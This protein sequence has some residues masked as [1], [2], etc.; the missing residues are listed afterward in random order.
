MT[1]VGSA[2]AAALPAT[3]VAAIQQ[4]CWR[5][6]AWTT[7]AIFGW[8]L[9]LDQLLPP[10]IP[11]LASDGA[12]VVLARD[13]SPLRAFANRQGVW[14]YPVTRAQV[15][16]L[17]VA[18][19]LGYE[20][21][22]FR[23]HLGINPLAIARAGAQWM[24]H[25]KLRSGASTLTMQVARLIEPIPHSGL[26]KLWQMLRAL[27]L[28]FR[29]SKNQ[30]IELYLNLAPFGGGIEGVQAASY[31]YL[32]KP[33]LA[34]SHAEA[35]LLA[36]LP[37][38][39]SRLRPDRHPER[40]R[41]ARDKV[42]ARLAQFGDWPPSVIAEARDEN[43]VAR[44]LRAPVSAALLAERLRTLDPTAR[45]ITTTLDAG[46]QRA[47]EDRLAAW[48][49]RFPEKTSA[50]ALIIDNASLAARAYVGSARFGDM[51]RAGHVDMIRARRS[52]GST[53]KPFLYALALDS[54][55]I[56]SES[57][58]IDAPQD[59]GGYRPANFGDSFNGPV[60]AAEALRLSLNVPA[61]DLLERITPSRFMA[62]LRHAGVTLSLPKAAKP[63]LTVILGGAAARL[64]Q[65]VGGYAALARGGVS[66]A[67]R[68]RRDD[69]VADRRLM[70]AGAAYIVRRMLEAHGRPDDP[71]VGFDLRRRTRIAWKTGTSYGFRDAWAIGVTPRYSVGVWIGRPDG[72]PSPGQYGAATAL[73][74][75]I[76]LADSLPRAGATATDPVPES[77]STASI[78]WPLGEAFDAAH[79]ELCS[80]RR[81][82]MLLDGRIPPT[83]PSRS[84]SASETLLQHWL[85]DKVS[86][87]RVLPD[88]ANAS[89]EA[90]ST[91]M[92]PLLT[93]PWLS[94]RER[95]A[96]TLPALSKACQG[97]ESAQVIARLHIDGLLA[98]AILRPAPG[99]KNL[100]TVRLRALGARGQVNWLLDGRLLTSAAA[101][102]SI[103]HRFDRT[104]RQTITAVDD[105]GAFDQLSV[106]V[107]LP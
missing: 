66:G 13:G 23:W 84:G 29:L 30:I 64:D 21:R 82:A 39:P 24:G 97:H 101:N 72:T 104:G 48:I 107:Q 11:D 85:R 22:W 105:S 93:S 3:A 18:A 47:T 25:G 33:A 98:D 59:F 58:L 28:E 67:V 76:A 31:A 6:V 32:G 99:A 79:P 38:A 57:L 41:S 103:D 52:P 55:L 50:A 92:W 106:R 17:Y 34:L 81:E 88:C 8:L 62:R 4:R 78:C 20:D 10:P 73:P 53:L 95:E 80:R 94:R 51:A 46:L 75:L 61:V 9:L 100:P 26:G 65:L 35:A 74:L 70:S 96:M 5:R 15:S 16:P 60:A 27:Q 7:L 42:L 12:T 77:V 63:N 2:A 40:A 86:G 36:V 49:E 71:E 14:R 44:S 69:P 1:Q 43:V 102:Q 19:V 45:S 91:A 68:F 87:L 89:P 90:A 54:G 83:L 56:H 37:Q